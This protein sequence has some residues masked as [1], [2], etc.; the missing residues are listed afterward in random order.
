MSFLSKLFRNAFGKKK[1]VE[2]NAQKRAESANAV[3]SEISNLSSTGGANPNVVS[4]KDGPARSKKT[5]RPKALERE[6]FVIGLDFGTAFTKVVVGDGIGVRHWSVPFD[7]QNS[8]PYLF[9]GVV[10]VQNNQAHIGATQ[11][12][13]EVIE[14]I[15]LRIIQNQVDPATKKAAVVYL[16]LVLRHTRTFLRETNIW[17]PGKALTEWFVNIG[18][19]TSAY[20]NE[21]LQS[22]YVELAQTAW[23]AS[24]APGPIS[25]KLVDELL[26]A[27]PSNPLGIN[28]DPEQQLLPKE[29]IAVFPEFVAQLA[30]Y[31]RSDQR[32]N[33]LHVLLDVGSGT[34]DCAA[35]NIRDH[36]G[37]DA[38]EILAKSVKPLGVRF[39]QKNRAS[40]GS[41]RDW[42]PGL[43][44]DQPSDTEYASRLG[45]SVDQLADHDITFF[46]KFYCQ[47]GTAM[48]QTKE[49]A[50]VATGPDL[51]VPIFLCGGGSRYAKYRSELA[52]FIDIGKT[53]KA[54]VLY[55]KR[56]GVPANLVAKGLASEDYDRISVAFGLSLFPENLGQVIEAQIQERL[57]IR[58][59]QAAYQDAYISKDQV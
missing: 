11:G 37:D 56:L 9:P 24:N 48:I 10:T 57:P 49:G 43:T 31:V 30:G 21:A 58:Q 4:S 14:D 5:S 34:V 25:I 23:L 52:R 59:T 47:I 2:D 3:T 7:Q 12:E 41:T 50:R 38:F 45:I 15:K 8:C 20:Q 22:L 55:Q 42:M 13:V 44:D 26:N 46:K 40:Y 17:S 19:P 18:L 51:G 27:I 28:P 36:E 32:E 53:Q 33:G 54:W 16:A 35:F 1:S 39:L 29:N 6:T